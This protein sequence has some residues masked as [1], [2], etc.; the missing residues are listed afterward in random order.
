MELS[1]SDD[2]TVKNL[3]DIIFEQLNR[4][5]ESFVLSFG[6]KQDFLFKLY[7]LGFRHLYCMDSDEMIY[8]R[9][10]YTK[11]K[12]LYGN[13]YESKLPSNM[14]N[15]VVCPS[16]LFLSDAINRKVLKSTIVEMKRI[17]KNNGFLI[18]RDLK[19]HLETDITGEWSKVTI[20]P[21][22]HNQNPLISFFLEYG[23]EPIC[24]SYK[25]E[26]YLSFRVKK[27][28]KMNTVREV[29]IVCSTLGLQDG[30]SRCTE[31]LSS[32]FA[33]EGVKVNLFRDIADI[34]NLNPII[35]EYEPG[36][37]N[38]KA[39]FP[40][41]EKVIIEAHSLPALWIH[42]RINF[43]IT[44][45]SSIKGHSRLPERKKIYKLPQTHINNLFLNLKALRLRDL[46]HYI[47]L[48]LTFPTDLLRSA[49]I[50][51]KFQKQ[52]LL[53]R[54]NKMAR[55][56]GLSRYTIMPL[57]AYPASFCSADT[58]NDLVIGSFGFATKSKNFDK[59]CELA[60]R[61]NIRAMLLLSI[62]NLTGSSEDQSSEIAYSIESKYR[63]DKIQIRIGYFSHE[64]I[65]DAMS[66]CSHI[67][68][69]QDNVFGSTAS[70][71]LAA[72]FGKPVIAT[73][74]FQSRDAQVYRVRNIEQINIEYLKEIK[75]PI[76][77]DDGFYYLKSI[78]ESM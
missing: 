7:G 64:Q 24:S 42:N 47:G 55:I 69:A 4:N 17:L 68:F 46:I 16:H 11:I 1:Y 66:E 14:F 62:N 32:R 33:L 2:N 57:S 60:I 5:T 67:V 25:N 23:F 29:N 26:D 28:D 38:F 75:E 53:V 31:N 49:L 48:V 52:V 74:T 54:D 77:L 39:N 9:P 37:P 6:E 27:N 3:V 59:I 58:D 15:A 36:M 34:K 35:V 22:L 10:N 44:Y 56:A 70:M 50:S 51:R 45:V 73:D 21:S 20:Q 40:R 18:I 13:A 76:N 8:D 63:S 71:R 78:L 19:N 43:I 61:L 72:S 30:V 65:R 12:Y 41:G